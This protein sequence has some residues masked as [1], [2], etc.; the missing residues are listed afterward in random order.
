MSRLARTR[1]DECIDT[2]GFAV[3]VLGDELEARD[4]YPTQCPCSACSFG[5]RVLAAL[6]ELKQP[7]GYRMEDA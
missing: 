6:A 1:V 5:R 3:M 4:H 7:E 2:I